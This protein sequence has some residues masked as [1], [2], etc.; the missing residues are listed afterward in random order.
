MAGPKALLVDDDRDVVK[1]LSTKLQAAG[2]QTVVAGDGASAIM[3]A[4]RQKPNVIVLDL[5]LPG[6]DGYLVMKRL[7]SLAPLAAIPI[8]VVT[9]KTLTA[10]EEARVRALAH[11]LYHKPV[12]L[13][14]LLVALRA[15]VGPSADA[16]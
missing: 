2:Y 1:L 10:D 15:A 7:K 16:H 12:Q 13:D 3:L 14:E 4:Q 6:G 5:G 9:G 8:V 11:S